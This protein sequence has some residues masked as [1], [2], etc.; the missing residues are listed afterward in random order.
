[1]VNLTAQSLRSVLVAALAGLAE[2]DRDVLLLTT[3]GEQGQVG[4]DALIRT[5]V[6]NRPGQLP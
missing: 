6:V 1:V 4:G 3:R 5:A 2:P